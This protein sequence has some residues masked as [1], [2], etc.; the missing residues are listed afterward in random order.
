MRSERSSGTPWLRM[1]A[2]VAAL[3]GC[4]GVI[5]DPAGGVGVG[6]EVSRCVAPESS[7][8]MPVALS[9]TGC[10]EADD[11]GRPAP[12]LVAFEVNAPFWTD[13]ADKE[14]WMALPPGGRIGIGL[15]GDFDLPVGT[16]LV[17]T[18]S[19]DGRRIETRLLV[20][21]ARGGW[22]GH[23]YEWSAA[24]REA[25]LVPDG[26][27]LT[28]VGHDGLGWEI[29][30]GAECVTCHTAE[31]GFSLGLELAQLDREVVDPATGE[32]VNQ[33]AMFEAMGWFAPVPSAAPAA[34][35]A[36]AASTAALVHRPL[37]DY[38]DASLPLADRARS[39]LHANCSSCHTS[40][41]N[42]CTGDFRSS[43][44]AAAM[45]VCDTQ[46]KQPMPFWPNGTL[47]L[48]PG[49]PARSAMSLRMHAAP[50]SGV[51]MPPMGRR[52]VDADGAALIDAWIASLAE[53]DAP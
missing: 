43:T 46:P 35:A 22:A 39:Y 18:M 47:L 28:D 50:D 37:V 5:S 26:D 41:E 27:F 6:L 48:A 16:V 13:G 8:Q 25:Y 32:G 15:D 49:D 2:F 24:E 51:A 44:D 36:S 23:A 30:S 33:L 4:T 29:P 3:A 12:A 53:C 1:A 31:R 42:F 14:R 10:F 20:N 45:G 19:I 11:P 40:P 34:S 9:D 38:R 52:R 21:H 7:D 17:K